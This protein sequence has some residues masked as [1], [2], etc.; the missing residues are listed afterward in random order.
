MV[1]EVAVEWFT[2]AGY[3]CDVAHSEAFAGGVDWSVADPRDYA[4]VAFVCG[5]LGDGEPASDFLRR[6]RDVPLVGLNLS[7][8]QPL[9]EWNPFDKL[10][11]RDSSRTSR[12]DMSFAHASTP[13]PVIGLVLVHRQREY[14]GALHAEVEDVVASVLAS[15][16]VA[17]VRIDTCFDP[18]NTTG[19]RTPAEVES[20][21]ARM[22]AVIT[23]RL[24]GMVLALK[25]GVPA[26]ALDPVPGGAKIRRQAD[27]IA[28]P[29][30]LTADEVDEAE[31]A[32]RLAWCL[33]PEGRAAATG[34]AER[35]A[36]G[37]DA[38]RLEL[39]EWL[40]AQGRPWRG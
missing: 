2:D 31:V 3:D 17:V 16:E 35:G 14:P 22:D 30:V 12:P 8:L 4:V 38:A 40:E 34:C 28:W 5:P 19:L 24:H 32:A 33:G 27:A 20:V 26:L 23:T 1:R 21:I 39:R 25:N 13:A 37:V 36:R 18:A 9:T 15:R 29:Q 10:I 7:M 11:E 6:F